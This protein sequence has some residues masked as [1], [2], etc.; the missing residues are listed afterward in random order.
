MLGGFQ[1]T[2]NAFQSNFQANTAPIS[3]G[4]RGI[5]GGKVILQTKKAGEVITYP[6]DFSRSLATGETITSVVSQCTVYTGVDPNP[7][8][9]IENAPSISGN[10]IFQTVSGGVVGVIYE[11]LVKVDTSLNNIIEQAGALAIESD[12]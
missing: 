5:P 8:D 12:L 6:F 4:G 7:E 1:S 11:I 9:L 2:F 10:E 3:L